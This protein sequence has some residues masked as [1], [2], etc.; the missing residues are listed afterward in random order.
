MIRR[1]LA[2]LSHQSR[3]GEALPGG[4]ANPE[5]SCL[6]WQQ[7]A[8]VT[9]PRASLL[10][11]EVQMVSPH[12]QSTRDWRQGGLSDGTGVCPWQNFSSRCGIYLPRT[13]A[14]QVSF[15]QGLH[16]LSV[17]FGCCHLQRQGPCYHM[18]LPSPPQAL[19]TVGTHFRGAALKSAPLQLSLLDPELLLGTLQTQPDRPS[20]LRTCRSVW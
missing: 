4:R 3:N 14:S 19:P 9:V 2:S 8:H 20:S 7:Q 12:F 18:R 15:S 6:A 10:A 13:P 1:F 16:F 17:P 5:R 11:P